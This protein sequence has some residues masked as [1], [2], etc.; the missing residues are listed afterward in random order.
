[1]GAFKNWYTKQ[2]AKYQAKKAENAA[3]AET[4][5]LNAEQAQK[6]H[7]EFADKTK[8]VGRKVQRV[9]CGLTF[10]LTFP[11]VGLLLGPIGF[12]LGLALGGLLFAAM[13]MSGKKAKA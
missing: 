13:V 3:K 11:I 9:G 10:L 7:E 6:E 12:V 2:D 5:K 4:V 1:M 8:A